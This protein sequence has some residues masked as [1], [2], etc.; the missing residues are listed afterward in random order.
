MLLGHIRIH[1]SGIPISYRLKGG[2]SVKLVQ[3]AGELTLQLLISGM[4]R[5]ATMA[6]S[7]SVD[8]L[9][10]TFIHLTNYS[11]NKLSAEYSDEQKWTLDEFWAHL[12]LTKP[13]IDQAKVWNSLINVIVKTLIA[14]V[15]HSFIR[16]F[17][18]SFIYDC[19]RRKISS[20][21]V[22]CK[23]EHILNYT[24]IN[25]QSNDSQ[26]YVLTDPLLTTT[27][28]IAPIHN[29]CTLEVFNGVLSYY[30]SLTST[31]HQRYGSP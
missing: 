9:D 7:E 3:P 2:H 27:I 11:L 16:L 8:S 5:F 21:A 6:Y 23:Q 17:I 25:S 15:F 20:I 22:S 1:I 31:T 28:Y 29:C 14:Y 12:K 18:Y 4:L 30:S 26:T 19:L 24:L 10:N 13:D